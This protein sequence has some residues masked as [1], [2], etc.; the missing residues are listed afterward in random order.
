MRSVPTTMFWLPDH[1]HLGLWM[2]FHV[3]VIG[4][5]QT[6]LVYKKFVYGENWSQCYAPHQV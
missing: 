2:P 6:L 3:M 5:Q 4:Q 1:N